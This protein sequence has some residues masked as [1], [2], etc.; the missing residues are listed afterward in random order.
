MKPKLIHSF[1]TRP[2]EQRMYGI[3]RL[4]HLAGD[5]WMFAL[6]VAYARRE[7][8]R[9]EL[10]TDSLGAAMLGHLPYDAVHLTL[11]GM[12]RHLSP[13][14]WAAGKMWALEAAGPG[15][16]HIDGDV[17][18]KD[19]ALLDIAPGTGI[20]AQE[21]ETHHDWMWSNEAIAPDWDDFCAVHGIVSRDEI[22]YNT[23]VLGLLD[24]GFR[25][26]YIAAYRRFAL[27]A[28]ACYGAELERGEWLTPDLFAEQLMMFQMARARGLR[29]HIVLPGGGWDAPAV[30]FQHLVT[31][32]K[33]TVVWKVRATLKKLFP[34]IYEK[35]E[36]LWQNI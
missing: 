23:G 31:S 19:A 22:N 28:T 24:D 14:F 29:E 6:S 5:V 7:G 17:F 26:D 35:T 10:H 9:I 33:Y 25:R 27:D 1:W 18:I 3:D 12:P 11:D 30:G 16:V 8:F 13:R 2:L 21:I 32:R 20:V 34:D 36:R 4:A 15:T